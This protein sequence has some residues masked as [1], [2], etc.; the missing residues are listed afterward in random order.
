M[1]VADFMAGVVAG[2]VLV[3]ILPIVHVVYSTI[4]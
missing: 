3:N 2:W 1:S 4:Q